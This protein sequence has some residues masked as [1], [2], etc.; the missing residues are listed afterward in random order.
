MEVNEV[1]PYCSVA[2]DA[3]GAYLFIDPTDN[4]PKFLH[5]HCL[6][7]LVRWFH[8]PEAAELRAEEQRNMQKKP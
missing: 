4:L 6:S 3:V 5:W 7:A 2:V 8:T 1:C